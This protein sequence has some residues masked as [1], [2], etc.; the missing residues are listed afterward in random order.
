MMWS[1]AR[2]STTTDFR[3][4]SSRNYQRPRNFEVS[5]RNLGLFRAFAK[6][7]RSGTGP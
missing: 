2:R 7:A 6:I 4:W 3:L 5:E 1:I